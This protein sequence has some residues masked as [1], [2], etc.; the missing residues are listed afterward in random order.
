MRSHFIK[1]PKNSHERK[2]LEMLQLQEKL[3]SELTPSLTPKSVE[4]ETQIRRNPT[5][6]A[7]VLTE[8][9]VKLFTTPHSTP[10][11]RQHG[12][13]PMGTPSSTPPCRGQAAAELEKEGSADTALQGWGGRARADVLTGCCNNPA[14]GAKRVSP[15]V[16]S[17]A[18]SHPPALPAA[19]AGSAL[20][21]GCLPA[22]CH[23]ASPS[24]LQRHNVP[25][26]CTKA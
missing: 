7:A 23:C 11:C 10:C 26:A 22:V 17:D 5:S 19:A 18:K 21:G 20:G 15:S 8:V 3:K 12:E 1:A 2:P 9:L 16:C 6:L 24:H 25:P 4:Q 13:N 14:R